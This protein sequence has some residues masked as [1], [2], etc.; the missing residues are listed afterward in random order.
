MTRSR[1][2]GSWRL[3]ITPLIHRVEKWFVQELQLKSGEH[4][5]F[6]LNKCIST[7]RALI[8][9]SGMD[10]LTQKRRQNR[11]SKRFSV[12]CEHFR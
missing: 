2:I 7:F 12:K 9:S 1:Y 4:V 10:Y 8:S 5:A 3:K 11:L 6:G